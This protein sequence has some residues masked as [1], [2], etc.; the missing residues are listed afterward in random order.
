M[1][2]YGK[3]V[4]RPFTLEELGTIFPKHSSKK[5]SNETANALRQRGFCVKHEDGSWQ[6]TSDGIRALYDTAGRTSPFS[7][8]D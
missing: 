2:L 1:L 4:R 3:M 8:S 6:I 7:R 5:R